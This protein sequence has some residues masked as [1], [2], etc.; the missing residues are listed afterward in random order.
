TIPIVFCGASAP[1]ADGFVASFARPGGNITGVTQYEP[2]MVGKWLGALKE[3]V[4]ALARVAIAGN[5]ETWP[6]NGTFYLGDF[7]KGAAG[8]TGEPITSS[9][10]HA[11]DIEAAMAALAAKPNGGLIVAPETFTT[12]NR[13]LFIT[14][15]ERHRLPAI[16]G[17]RQFPASGGLM[18]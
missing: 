15:A 12:A 3:I 14:L 11:A 13:E 17:L 4:P 10:R 6:V 9:V 18:S 16:Y 1:V 2:T 5:P 7:A 8:L